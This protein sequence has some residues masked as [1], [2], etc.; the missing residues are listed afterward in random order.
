MI[1]CWWSTFSEVVFVSELRAPQQ[2]PPVCH[3]ECENAFSG[4]DLLVFVARWCLGAVYIGRAWSEMV[5]V[6]GS[7]AV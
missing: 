1:R 4:M 7:C 6:A 5:C 3:N 2:M